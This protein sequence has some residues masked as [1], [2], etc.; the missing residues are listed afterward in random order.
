M[1]Y[2]TSFY[3]KFRKLYAQYQAGE[4]SEDLFYYL[5]GILMEKEFNDS[6][7]KQIRSYVHHPTKRRGL[8]YINY[9][10]MSGR[11]FCSIPSFIF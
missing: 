5:V 4:Y 6:L 1:K 10:K 11:M 7:N 2:S 3:K 8:S 9:E